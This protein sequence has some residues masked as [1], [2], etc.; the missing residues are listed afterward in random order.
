MVIASSFVLSP[1]VP[2][3]LGAI[4]VKLLIG[5]VLFITVPLSLDESVN[6]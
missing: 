3:T 5:L 2:S 6:F 4:P 1:A